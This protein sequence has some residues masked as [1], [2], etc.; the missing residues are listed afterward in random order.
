MSIAL[1][2]PEFPFEEPPGSINCLQKPWNGVL[3]KVD[4]IPFTAG[5][6]VTFEVTVYSDTTTGQTLAAKTQG[7]VS[8]TADTT[9]VSYTI[10]WDGV[11]DA[12]TEGSI[13]VFYTLTPADGSTPSTGSG[14]L[15]ARG[16]V[17][18]SI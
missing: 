14:L 7:I 10:P 18:S 5:D 2:F 17:V 4:Q 9:S 15:L 8:V 13:T 3:V 1:D 16:G 6:K 12:A 11:L